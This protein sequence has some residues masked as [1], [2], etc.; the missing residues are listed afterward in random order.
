MNDD[1]TTMAG[2]PKVLI[3]DDKPANLRVLQELLRDFEVEVV[4]ATSGEE[5]LS[6]VM[7]HQFAVILLDVKMPG[8]SGIETANLML[9]NEDTMQTPVIFIT[10][11]DMDELDQ[12]EGY[13][14]GAV[15]YII[16][17]IIPQILL[18]KVRVFLQLYQQA[19]ELKNNNEL[20]E[21]LNN[22]RQQQYV[23]TRRL[24]NM[25]PDGILVVNPD[26]N[27]LYA[28]TAAAV[29][30]NDENEQLEGTVFGFPTN[31]GQ[32]KE[33][34]IG[35]H[36][37]EMSVTSLVWNGEDV[38]LVTLHDITTMKQ[39]ELRLLQL[40]RYDQLTGLANRRYCLEF[41]AM[42]LIRAK[43]RDGYIAVMFL[44]LDKFKEI[45]DTLGHE[46]GD[47]VLITVAE[48]LNNSV[49]E[50]D[51]V[52]RFGGDEF[53]VVLDDISD[54]KDTDVI[55]EKV[56]KAMAPPHSLSGKEIVV[57]CSIGIATSPLSGT[58]PDAL[59]KVADE[60][61]YKIKSKGGNSSSTNLF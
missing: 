26:N 44:D 39:T 24:L 5:T 21:W 20:L 56:L 33:I 41:I 58:E 38:F 12:I 42:A 35:D 32:S 45:N 9:G 28:N 22:D 52:S 59:I 54:P 6:L 10:G 15:D 47:E 3:V 40:A 60:H 14:A 37:V 8:M 19:E 2:L 25:N 46:A 53:L 27:I 48:R 11:Y 51:L 55:A 30:F 23:Q 43:R 57:N 1:T 36:I 31:D 61:M 18:G 4:E 13:S 16:K 34:S 17:P 49:R 7:R 50:G 29:L